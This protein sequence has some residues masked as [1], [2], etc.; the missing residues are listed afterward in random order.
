MNWGYK[1][2]LVYTAFAVF[3]I[4]LVL[5]SMNQE[6]DLV[7]E[8]YYEKELKFQEQIDK[9]NL[10]TTNGKQVVWKHE[11]NSL[12]LVFPATENVRGE[13]KLFR[14][15]DAAKDYSVVVKPDNEGKQQIDLTKISKGKYLL[16]IDWKENGK[17]YF[18][19]TVI[20]I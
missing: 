4:T 6:H 11:A 16:Q 8:D 14:P 10:V 18:Q 13:I 17:A 19:E 1:I 9:Q 20:I 2:A 3:M 7:A 15:S 5:K 12:E